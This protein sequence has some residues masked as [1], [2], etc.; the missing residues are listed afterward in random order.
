MFYWFRA[1]QSINCIIFLFFF[2][3]RRRHTRYWRD[4]S[5]DVCSS[6]LQRV[7][8]RAL[9]DR[10]A[11]PGALRL[12]VDLGDAV[13]AAPD[14]V[15]VEADHRVAAAHRAALDRFEEERRAFVALAQ[16]QEGRD[17]R[18]EVA[19]EGCPDDAGL[20]GPIARGEGLEARLGEHE[21]SAL[22]AGDGA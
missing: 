17:R 5:S 13:A 1:T 2:S 16:L 15:G 14:E 7:K 3:S 4:W 10:K 6:D 8:R 12:A 9:V 18:L 21:G 20:A 11:P 19:D 22:A